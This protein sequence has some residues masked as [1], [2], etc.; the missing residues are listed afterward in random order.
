MQSTKAAIRGNDQQAEATFD[1]VRQLTGML[2]KTA[3]QAAAKFEPVAIVNGQTNDERQDHDRKTTT[4]G[5]PAL[6]ERSMVGSPS[7]WA[8]AGSVIYAVAKPL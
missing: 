5:S 3:D 6:V 2:C 7:W 4:S 8:A 1:A